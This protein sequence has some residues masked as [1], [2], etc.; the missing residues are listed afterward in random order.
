MKRLCVLACLLGGFAAAYAQEQ[1]PLKKVTFMPLWCPQAQ[2]AGYYVAYDKGIYRKYGLD[3]TIIPGGP[4]RATS[5]YLASGKADIVL[6]WLATALQKR[7]QKAPLVNIGQIVQRSALML[8]AKKSSGIYTWKDI[9]GKKVSLWDADF[10]IQPKAFFRKY[11]LKVT[12]IPQSYTVNLFL[13]GGVDVV[14]AMKYNEYH[15]ILDCG[16]D[17][18]ELT[19]FYF[20]EHD[21]NFPEDGIYML[22]STYRK[23]P[24]LAAAFVR[25]SLE[26]WR[27]AFA[28]KNE[29]ET[30]K[31]ILNYMRAAKIP[32][33]LLHQRWMLEHMNEVMTGGAGGALSGVLKQ[34]DYLRVAEELK[35]DGLLDV[36]PAFDSFYI[37]V[38]RMDH[39]EK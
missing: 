18:E 7:A 24:A 5:E 1:K 21:L 37:P 33:N 30:L 14:S 22:E 38:T 9:N 29:D 3:V 34:S 39:V 12:I 2:F 19:A 15:T 25:A 13:R 36:V 27:Y 10:Q 35:K 6:M 28:H 17:E 20:Y 31:I 23:D 4:G 8:V 26:G 11:G 32:A 16:Y